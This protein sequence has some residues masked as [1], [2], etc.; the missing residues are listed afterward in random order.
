[1]LGFF[2]NGFRHL[3]NSVRPVR[4]LA[5]LSGLSIRVF[6]A[7]QAAFRM[8][9]ADVVY[10]PISETIPMLADGSYDGQENPFEN[11]V[12]YGMQAHQRYYTTTYHSYL[13][14]PV[15]V[16]GPTFDAWP[17]E[18]QAEI[19]EAVRD[20]VNEQRELHDLAEIESAAVIREAGG[21]IVELTA[22]QRS[23]FIAAVEPI[24]LAARSR[25]DPD[26]L[27]EVGL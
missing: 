26:L 12:G 11:V 1:V 7:V 10:A 2:E 19:R 18:L 20:A 25:Y 4:T 6:P 22:E 21:E 16:H 5:D 14:R 15:F 23:Y 8:L 9:G 17:E 13:S 27:A 24:Y 3:S